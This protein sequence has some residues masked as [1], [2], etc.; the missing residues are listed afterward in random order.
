[1]IY[2]LIFLFNLPKFII[3]IKK[4]T[5]ILHLN[6]TSIFNHLHSLY[7]IYSKS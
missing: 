7:F 2:Y 1:M 6:L 3:F 4:I 5:K